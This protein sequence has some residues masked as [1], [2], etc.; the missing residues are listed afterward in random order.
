VFARRL[1]AGSIASDDDTGWP[2]T[3]MRRPSRGR[4]PGP[5]S[6]LSASTGWVISP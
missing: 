5:R 6:S 2:E 4:S 3:C 1:A